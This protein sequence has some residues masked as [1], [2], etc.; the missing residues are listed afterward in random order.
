MNAGDQMEGFIHHPVYYRFFGKS[1]DLCICMIQ[2]FGKNA[3]IAVIKKFH[4]SSIL[5]I[6][7]CES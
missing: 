4:K 3:G 2:E 5:R 6:P 1:G 7:G